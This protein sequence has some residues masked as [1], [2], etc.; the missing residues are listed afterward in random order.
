MRA[1]GMREEDLER[2][3]DLFRSCEEARFGLASGGDTRQ[4][5]REVMKLLEDVIKRAEH[6]RSLS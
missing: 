3:D 1:A 4:R 5:A 6:V 2:I